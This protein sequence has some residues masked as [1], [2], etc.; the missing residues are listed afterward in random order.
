MGK[1]QTLRTQRKN[2]G[3]SD[4]GGSADQGI[5]FGLGSAV[6]IAMDERLHGRQQERCA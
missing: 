3:G 2:N 5:G 1:N 4:A 6:K